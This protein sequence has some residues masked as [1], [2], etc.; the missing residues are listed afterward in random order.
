MEFIDLIKKSKELK[1]AYALLNRTEG[2]KAWGVNE[3]MQGFV[4]DVGDLAK[5]IMAKKGFRYSAKSDLD[6]KLAHE[7]ADCLWSIITIAD[8]LDIDLEEE[9]M[10]TVNQLQEKISDRNVIKA[11]R[12]KRI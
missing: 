9:F 1:Q 3:Y 12:S 8:E 5:L 2:S 11:K 4:G 7:L 10:K 6:D